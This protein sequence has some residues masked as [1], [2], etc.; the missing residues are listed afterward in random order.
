MNHP[1]EEFLS[2][3]D[4]AV[5]KRTLLAGYTEDEQENFIRLCQRTQLDPFSKQI[6][7]TRRWVKKGDSRTPTLVP[8]TSV[9]GLTAIAARTGQYD[10]CE[11]FWAGNDGV[12]KEEWIAEEFPVAAKCI[13]YHKQRSHP[14]VGIASWAGYCGQTYNASAKR[15]ET[16][17]FWERLGPFM[18]G[19][20]A[21]AQALRGA[22]PDQCS[23]L[24]ISEELQGGISEADQHNDEA[25]ITENRKKEEELLKKAAAQGVKIVE[26]KPVKK[27]TPAEAA[28]PA[29]EITGTVGTPAH[30]GE[31]PQPVPAPAQV[32][33]SAPQEEPDDLDMEPSQ[34]PQPE[35]SAEAPAGPPA[36][37]EHVIQGLRNDKYL[38]RKVGDLSPV[39]LAAIEA[40]WLPKVREVLAKGEKLKQA[41]QDDA[42]A[43]EEAIKHSKLEKPW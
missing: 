32:T 9:I 41:Q 21:K 2:P 37:A 29:P 42:V 10:G 3:E 24:Y 25:K 40:N 15:W 26:S 14:E 36:W 22:Y 16:T 39:E 34:P 11:T 27:P 8:V 28:A 18:L 6:Y 23:N 30:P 4:I 12:W 7:A 19:K 20:C 13:V 43:F 5:L 17:E 35:P 1:S 38:G 31:H 33:H